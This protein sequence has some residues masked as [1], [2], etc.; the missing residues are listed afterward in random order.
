MDVNFR[1]WRKGEEE[2]K[3]EAP[4]PRG[5]Q[6]AQSEEF[7]HFFYS[8]VLFFI[9]DLPKHVSEYWVELIYVGPEI[10]SSSVIRF[11]VLVCFG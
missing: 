9:S 11:F 8:S 1:E 5:Q 2:L 3:R 4:H 10:T 7:R 6:T